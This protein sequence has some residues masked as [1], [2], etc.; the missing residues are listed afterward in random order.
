MGKR[1]VILAAKHWLKERGINHFLKADALT[2]YDDSKFR[3]A[4]WYPNTD[5]WKFVNGDELRG[6]MG[7]IECLRQLG[8]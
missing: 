4:I 8:K 3:I 5:K 6:I 1:E 2:I 7:K